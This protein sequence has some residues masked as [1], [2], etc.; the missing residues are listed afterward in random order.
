MF[1]RSLRGGNDQNR[2]TSL[3]LCTGFFLACSGSPMDAADLGADMAPSAG[4]LAPSSQFLPASS[5]ADELKIDPA[6]P[7]GV[8]RRY[9]TTKSLRGARWGS[10][11][12]P[13]VT[14]AILVGGTSRMGVTRF[15]LPPASTGVLS[16]AELAITEATGVP[17]DAYY[18][19]MVDLPLDGAALWSYTGSGAHFPGEA[20]LYSADYVT[21]RSRAFTNGFFEVVSP[22]AGL[23]F[24]TGLS[25][26]KAATSATDDNGLWRSALCSGSVVPSGACEASRKLVG[27][28]GYSGPVTSDAQGNVFVAASLS[29]G[30]ATDEVY[31]LTKAESLSSGTGALTP[32]T[33]LSLS[34]SGTSS[35]AAKAPGAN[36]PGWLL[37]KGYDAAGAV[38]PATAQAYELLSGQTQLQVRGAAIPGALQPGAAATGFS[39]LSDSQGNLWVAVSEKAQSVL[40]ELAIQPL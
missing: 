4:D 17:A 22:A 25:G 7:F 26:L 5:Y 37:Q 32:A 19:A 30:A 39:M 10:H 11:G 21:P 35:I 6:F 8:T 33:L 15:T 23:L 31:A 16:T 36:Q 27:W 40:L 2:V 28:S 1:K 20:M 12:G 3:L 29:A 13:M 9:T 18:N 24:Y 38:K 14:G 34:T